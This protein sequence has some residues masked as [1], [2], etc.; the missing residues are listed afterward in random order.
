MSRQSAK[1]AKDKR[2]HRRNNN[3]VLTPAPTA[4]PTGNNAPAAPAAF[5]GS[6]MLTPAPV[7][8]AYTPGHVL[9]QLF[10][11]YVNEGSREL[12]EQSA[13]AELETN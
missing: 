6:T 11:S 3:V 12:Q 1:R 13:R 7:Q 10:R 8:V 5:P 4:H 9:T 2:K